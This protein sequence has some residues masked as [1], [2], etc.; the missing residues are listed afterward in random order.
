MNRDDLQQKSSF[1]LERMGHRYL[2]VTYVTT[3]GAGGQTRLWSF[4]L[5]SWLAANPGTLIVAL[6]D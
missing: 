5:V 3:Q 1:E 4:E 6:R 2:Q